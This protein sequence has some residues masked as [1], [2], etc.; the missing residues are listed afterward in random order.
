[1]TSCGTKVCYILDTFA[2]ESSVAIGKCCDQFVSIQQLFYVFQYPEQLSTVTFFVLVRISV[3]ALCSTEVFTRHVHAFAQIS[4]IG[5][6]M[7]IHTFGAYFGLAVSFF[8]WKEK[9]TSSD[10]KEGSVYHSDI[11]AMI[12]LMNIFVALVRRLVENTATFLFVAMAQC[13]E[14][15]VC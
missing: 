2:T 1:M 4:D 6:S 12:G 9:I 14:I 15:G 11:F 3:T 5:G 10:T 13:V 8:H 7:V